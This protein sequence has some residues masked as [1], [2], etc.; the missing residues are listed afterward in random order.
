MEWIYIYEIKH[1]GLR[2]PEL[3][4]AD[5]VEEAIRKFNEYWANDIDIFPDGIE[6]VSLAHQ[7]EVIK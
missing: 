3:V 5:S 7:F 4:I 2:D 6:S 1:K